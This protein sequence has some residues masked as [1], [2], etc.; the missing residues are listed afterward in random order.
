[1]PIV[2]ACTWENYYNVGMTDKDFIK[3]NIVGR[4]E[5]RKKMF[6]HY[7]RVL[8]SALLF[9][10]VSAAVFAVSEP[11]V[12]DHIAQSET[13][14]KAEVTLSGEDETESVPAESAGA[15]DETVSVPT[16]AI[17][18]V[19]QSEMEKYP[20]SIDSY[21][22][23]IANLAELASGADNSIV[24]VKSIADGTDFFGGPLEAS[25]TYA[26]IVI[27]TTADEVLILTSEQAVGNADSI[28][29]TLRS[30][31][32]L[33]GSL[34][35]VDATDGAAVVALPV[36]SL[37]QSELDQMKAIPLGNSNQ[38]HRGDALIAVGAPSG[39]VHSSAYGFVSFAASN[40]AVADGSLRVL[41]SDVSADAEAGTFLL[42]TKGE[43]VGWVST[44]LGESGA[45]GFVR[46][47]GLSDFRSRIERIS[48][49]E[50]L[51]YFGIITQEVSRSMENSGLPAGIYVRGCAQNSPAYLAGIQ[52]GDIVTEISGKTIVSMQDYNAALGALA[53]GEQVSVKV[54]RQ[55]GDSYRDIEFQVTAGTR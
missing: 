51:P 26:G 44:R 18:D 37:L 29:V 43:L 41:V 2:L 45:S 1:M 25:D 30:G 14:P 55:S 10:A 6:R 40:Y 24:E 11:F 23:M 32:T 39:A 47:A 3:E 16:E 28:Q 31:S 35:G 53:P 13:E 42:N 49:G 27:A 21:D 34:K 54:L 22:A 48:N 4:G 36:P 19:V 12:S 17:E 15:E 20:F 5:S 46:I 38:M 9:G 52:S 7:F 33:Q 8:F 50:A